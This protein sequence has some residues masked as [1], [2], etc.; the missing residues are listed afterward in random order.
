MSKKLSIPLT[1]AEIEFEALH[2]RFVDQL[3]NVFSGGQHDEDQRDKAIS[4]LAAFGPRDIVELNFAAQL[5]LLSHCGMDCFPRACRVDE[6]PAV[7]DMELRHSEKLLDRYERVLEAFEKRRRL[8]E[9]K[10]VAPNLPLVL[11][12]HRS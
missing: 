4:A 10:K 9:M 7:R 11:I 6:K 12:G 3:S 5:V 1:I 2:A 8:L